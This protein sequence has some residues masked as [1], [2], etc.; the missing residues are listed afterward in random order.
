M[1]GVPITA[2]SLRDTDQI[3]RANDGD[4]ERNIGHG[5]VCSP[6]E[7]QRTTW[8]VGRHFRH[9]GLIRLALHRIPRR[10]RSRFLTTSTSFRS[11]KPTS[12]RR[13]SRLFFCKSYPRSL[14]GVEPAAHHVE[15]DL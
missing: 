1:Q 2:I 5:G 6:R 7:C 4:G 14:G 9:D 15:N 11:T 10:S 12:A 8:Q 3:E 13:F